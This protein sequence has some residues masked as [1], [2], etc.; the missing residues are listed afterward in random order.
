MLS[1]VEQV[2]GP[3]AAQRTATPDRIGERPG[4][5]WNLGHDQ[6]QYES[7]GAYYPGRE[8][9]GVFPLIAVALADNPDAVRAAYHE[10]WHAIEGTLTKTE[11]AILRRET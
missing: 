8:R 6:G 5:D 11:V 2:A 9:S 4:R 1:A 7:A 10:G 3:E